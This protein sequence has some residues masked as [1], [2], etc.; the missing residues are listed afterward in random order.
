LVDVI[1]IFEEA[2]KQKTGRSIQKD[3]NVIIKQKKAEKKLDSSVNRLLEVFD[4]PNSTFY[5]PHVENGVISQR[6]SYIDSIVRKAYEKDE[7]N[8]NLGR[9]GIYGVIQ[10][11]DPKIT[12]KQIRNSKKRLGIIS[13]KHIAKHHKPKEDKDVNADVPNLLNGIT[14]CDVP[15]K[16]FSS[17]TT[18]I[19]TKDS[20]NT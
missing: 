19:K 20:P 11:I 12:L 7:L 1:K 4:I 2:Y 16:Y 15:L 18:C 9:D 13:T 17:D 14:K 5:K 8:S 6:K 10:K 3:A